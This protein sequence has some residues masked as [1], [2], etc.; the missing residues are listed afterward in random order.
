[1]NKKYGIPGEKVE[2]IINGYSHTN[3]GAKKLSWFFEVD[4]KIVKAIINDFK[5]RKFNECME[6]VR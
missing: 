1:M 3:A 4:L 6:N 2:E 5:K